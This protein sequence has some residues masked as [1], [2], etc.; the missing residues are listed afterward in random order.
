MLIKYLCGPF[1]S[2]GTF[3]LLIYNDHF[4]VQ[5][6][7]LQQAPIPPSHRSAYSYMKRTP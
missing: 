4:Q 5:S 7:S 6:Y 2:V 3:Y 1:P